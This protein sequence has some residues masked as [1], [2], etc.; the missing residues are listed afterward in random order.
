MAGP[1]DSKGRFVP[2]LSGNPA[3]TGS[4]RPPIAKSLSELIR[5]AGEEADPDGS[6]KTRNQL[7]AE[8]IWLMALKGEN[9]KIR[10]AATR[11]ILDR[12]EGR[13]PVRVDISTDGASLIKAYPA[14][15]LEK[16]A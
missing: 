3:G 7:V 15:L 16:L 1:R 8:G 12:T 14:E 10:L 5:R 4:G 9:E 11:E 2:G 6:G 13:A